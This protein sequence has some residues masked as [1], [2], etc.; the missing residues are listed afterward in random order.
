VPSLPNTVSLLPA[1]TPYDQRDKPAITIKTETTKYTLLLLTLLW[2]LSTFW[3]L[4]GVGENYYLNIKGHK[5][6]KKIFFE[7]IK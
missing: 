6:N 5:I 3:L 1:L 7:K 2:T 4:G